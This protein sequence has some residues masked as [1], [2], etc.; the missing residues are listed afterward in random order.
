MGMED[1][2]WY[3]DKKI[4]WERG[5]LQERNAK[6]RHFPGYAWWIAVVVFL[7]VAAALVRRI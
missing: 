7:L 4:D 2:D 1:R 5:G 3:R 6:K